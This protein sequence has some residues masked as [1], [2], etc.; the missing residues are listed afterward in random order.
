MQRGAAQIALAAGCEIV[1]VLVRCE[2]EF[3]SKRQWPWQAPARRPH[4]VIRVEPALTPCA[5]PRP[6]EPAPRAARR[7]TR[8]FLEWYSRRAGAAPL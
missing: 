1:P 6:G 8:E 7:L 3:L 5:E 2:P 4:F